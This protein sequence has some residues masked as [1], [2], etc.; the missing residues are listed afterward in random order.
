MDF[1]AVE[2]NL[3]ESFRI[4]ASRPSGE[5][6]EYPGVSIAAAGVAFQMFN[7]AFLSAAVKTEEELNRRI[8]LTSVH[9]RARGWEWAWW[10][11]ESWVAER[12]RPRIRQ[13]MRNHRLRLSVEMPGMV[14]E[15]LNP[16][17]YGL[18]ALEIRRVADAATRNDFCSVGSFC[19]NVPLPWFQEV[20]SADTV[21]RGFHGYVGYREGE[22]VSTAATVVDAGAV[23]VYNV[24]TLPGHQ[25]RGYGE[26]IM[27]HALDRARERYGVTR[28]ILQST[29]QGQALYTRMGYQT[30]TKIAVYAS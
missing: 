24:A 16:P 13:V 8:Q 14:A 19:F 17:A 27:R 25:G 12:L 20:F 5:V 7:A 21:W 22:P 10:L 1:G 4:F 23:G 9:F 3:R 29:A 2:R 26:A 28:T 11:C 15:R 30:V 6:R 18:P